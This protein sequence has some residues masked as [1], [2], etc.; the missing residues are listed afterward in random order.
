MI[1]NYEKFLKESIDYSQ[2][3]EFTILKPDLSLDKLSELIKNAINKNIKIISTR[4]EYINDIKFIIDN[5]PIKISAVIDFPE[6]KQK[7]KD[8]IKEINKSI[9]YGADEIELTIDT[10]LFKKDLNEKNIEKIKTFKEELKELSFLCH[11][12]GVIFKLI[13]NIND[14]TLDQIKTFAQT[15]NNS[16]IDYIQTST[17]YSTDFKKAK[18]LHKITPDSIKLKIAGEIRTLSDMKKY[19]NIADRIGTSSILL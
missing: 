12:N 16:G 15:I 10:N 14:L 19:I 4:S 1:I 9:T 18:F 17:G 7:Y 13:V 11:K 6:G 2:I 5:E 3:I 8:N